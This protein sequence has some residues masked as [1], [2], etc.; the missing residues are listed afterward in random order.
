MAWIYLAVSFCKSS[1]G[2]C[3]VYLLGNLQCILF[4]VVQSSD[5][6]RWW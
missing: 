6:H 3:F 5:K 1:T 2:L 4:L